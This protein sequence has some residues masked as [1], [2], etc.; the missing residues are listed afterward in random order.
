MTMDAGI[1]TYTSYIICLPGENEKDALNTI[2]YAKKMATPMAM[3]Y[4]PIPFPKTELWNACKKDGGLREDAKWEDYN[5]WDAANPVYVNPLIGKEKMQ[6]I[7]SY[8][9]SSYYKNP[10]VIWRNLKEILLLRQ[11]I[12]RYWYALK[13]V[14]IAAS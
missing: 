3:F 1:Y 2:E 11:G 4:L 14:K 6:E 7:L 5:A 8:A 10:K 13:S 9:Y 12:K